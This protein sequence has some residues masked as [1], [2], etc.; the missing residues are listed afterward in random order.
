M[1]LTFTGRDQQVVPV[2][3]T[4]VVT[5]AGRTQRLPWT[6]YPR[7]CNGG[8]DLDLAGDGKPEGWIPIDY[9]GKLKV[10]DMYE[11]VSVDTLVKHGGKASLRLAPLDPRASRMA[12]SISTRS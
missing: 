7:V 10:Q 9:S 12:G 2:L 8:F 1:T 4:L 11:K 6:I 5:A 3:S